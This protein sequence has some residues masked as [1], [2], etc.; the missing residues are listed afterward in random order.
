[1]PDPK[2]QPGICYLVGAGPGDLGLVTLKARGCIEKADVLVYDYLCNPAMLAWAPAACEIIYAGKKAGCHAIKQVDINALLVEKAKAGKTV[3]RLK[4]GDPYVFGRGA[5]EAQDLVKA[6]IAFEVV[7]GISSVIAG[8]SYAGIPVTHREFV[9]Q[10]TVFTGHEDPGK[11]SSSVDFAAIAK[12]EGDQGH[13]HGRRADRRDHAKVDRERHEAGHAGRDDPLGHDGAPADHS[14]GS[15][16]ASRASWPRPA[17]R[18]P[19]WWSL[20]TW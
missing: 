16:T 15:S 19:R 3:V 11:T 7:P 13:A 10:L 4:G 5:E 20:A 12:A 6:G 14:R 1:M 18:R 8:P 17:S 2:P 9:S